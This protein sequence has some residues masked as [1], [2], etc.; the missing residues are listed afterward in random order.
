MNSL[1]LDNETKFMYTKLIEYFGEEKVMNMLN[2]KMKEYHNLLPI[3]NVIRVLYIEKI[4][5]NIVTKIKDLLPGLY[6]VTVVGTVIYIAPPQVIEKDDKKYIKYTFNIKDETGET[7]V[8][9]YDAQILKDLMLGST[10]RI[11][12]GL[13]KY[14][15]IYINKKTKINI[16]KSPSLSTIKEMINKKKGRFY[17]KGTVVSKPEYVPYNIKGKS[18]N[19]LTFKVADTTG[20][21]TVTVWKKCKFDLKEGCKIRLENIDYY[22]DEIH[23]TKNSRVV[24]IHC[25]SEENEVVGEFSEIYIENDSIY[26]LFE[27]RKVIIPKQQILKLFNIDVFPSDLSLYTLIELKK[28]DLLKKTLSLVLDE[29]DGDIYVTDIHF[30]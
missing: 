5:S 3:E 24:I 21:A 13:C 15:K 17:L 14:S 29:K 26:G 4:K 12:N 11:I 27:G 28:R 30:V 25:P 10:I 8:I 6:F 23:I 16:L 19:I 22:N 18:E 1:N 20:T 9:C 2:K 7:S